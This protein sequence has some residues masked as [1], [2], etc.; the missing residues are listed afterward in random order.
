MSLPFPAGSRKVTV[1]A[2]TFD[3]L[4]AK[5]TLHIQMYMYAALVLVLIGLLDICIDILG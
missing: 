4:T 1:G 2:Q 3:L 5:K